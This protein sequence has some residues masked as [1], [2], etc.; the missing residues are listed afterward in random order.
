MEAV[1]KYT[2]IILNILIPLAGIWLVCIWGPKLLRFFLPFVIGWILAMIANPLVR[3]LESRLKI[4]RKHGSAII[5][6]LVLAGIIGI[7]YLLISKLVIEMIGFTKNLPVLY[8]TVTIEVKNAMQNFEHLFLRLPA[9]VQNTINRFSENIGEYMGI[10]VQKLASPTVTV[11]GNVAK[12]IPGALVN[13]IITILSSY[14]FIAERDKIL[15]FWK[16]HAPESGS[17]YL[18]FLKKD[19]RHLIG[20]YFLAQFRIMFIV[21]TVLAAGFLIL[22]VDYALLLAV[23]IAVL[24]FLP[25]FGTGTALIPWS[26]VKLLSGEYAFAAGLALIYVLTQVLRQI[27]QPKIVGD[28]MGL[29]P[30]LTLFFLYIGFKFNGISGMILAVPLGMVALNL[31]EYGMFDSMIENIRILIHDINEFR[32][33]GC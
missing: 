5:V 30:L 2:K 29:P 12:G 33:N 8:E 7:L 6:V 32:K 31:Y 9:D 27:I 10:L 28:T 26:L 23:L 4:V 17:K 3:F 24:D 15:E 16:N 1:K 21:G 11:A 18:S 22:G 25:L 20:G 14:F 13:S 19:I